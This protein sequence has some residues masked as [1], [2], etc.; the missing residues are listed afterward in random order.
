[1]NS[2]MTRRWLDN[3]MYEGTGPPVSPPGWEEVAVSDRRP[4]TQCQ[5]SAAPPAPLPRGSHVTAAGSGV[6]RPR[7]PHLGG[8]AGRL[9]PPPRLRRP[10]ARLPLGVPPGPEQGARRVAW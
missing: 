3:L 10:H 6:D 5:F 8:R 2:A 9:R 7:P 1:M 4:A